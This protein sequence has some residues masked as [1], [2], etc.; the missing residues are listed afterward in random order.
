MLEALHLVI[1]ILI[2]AGVIALHVE[3]RLGRS[4]KAP[5]RTRLRQKSRRLDALRLTNL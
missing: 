4:H 1:S 5:P 2:L 3:R